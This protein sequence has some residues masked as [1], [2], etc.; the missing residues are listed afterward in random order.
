MSESN[1]IIEQGQQDLIVEKGARW[2]LK[3]GE[4]TLSL[5]KGFKSKDNASL[6]VESLGRSLDW[7]AGYVFRLRGGKE[8]L[9]IVSRD[10]NLA[11]V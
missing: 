7:R 11:K 4:N 6:W 3:Q 10:G 5:D 1:K 9:K 2:F 8:D